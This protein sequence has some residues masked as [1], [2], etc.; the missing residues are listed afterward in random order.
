MGGVRIR[1]ARHHV[2]AGGESKSDLYLETL[3][4][5]TPGA[6][7]IPDYAALI[8]E[9]RLPERQ[10]NKSGRDTI[11]PPRWAAAM[12]W[13]TA[14]RLGGNVLLLTRVSTRATTDFA[15]PRMSSS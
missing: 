6:I 7:S 10:T 9:L 5:F 1:R 15:V 8:R 2:P 11:G 3:P 12:T 4:L 13:P 14:M